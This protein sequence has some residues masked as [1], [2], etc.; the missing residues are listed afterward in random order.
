MA[1]LRLSLLGSFEAELD[2]KPVT[3]FATTK[4]Q[5]LLAYLAV[6]SHRAHRR[7]V[8]AALLWP[9]WPERAA[10]TNLRNALSKLRTAIGDRGVAPGHHEPYLLITRETVQF[11]AA[12]AHWP[13]TAGLFSYR[14]TLCPLRAISS[15]ASIPAIPPP[16]TITFLGTDALSIEAASRWRKGLTVQELHWLPMQLLQ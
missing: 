3:G 12:S 14:L 9:D 16:T 4:I 11:N 8:L 13:P 2:G 5:A 7:E 6:E 15:A 10:R 1:C